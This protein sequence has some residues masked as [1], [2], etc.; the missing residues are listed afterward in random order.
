MRDRLVFLLAGAAGSQVTVTL[1]NGTQ[2]VGI[3]GSAV[4]ESE[5]GVTLHCARKT[6]PAPKAGEEP[7]IKAT[8]ILQPRDVKSMETAPIDLYSSTSAPAAPVQSA[9]LSLNNDSFRTDVQITGTSQAD[10]QLRTLQQWSADDGASESNAGLTSSTS[11]NKAWNQFAANEKL[12]GLRS[13]YSEELYTTKLD[14]SGKD[15]SER[16]RKAEALA[17]EIMA[18]RWLCYTFSPFIRSLLTL[19]TIALWLLSRP[20][21][22]TPMLLK[23]AVR[24]MN[25][26]KL[27]FPKRTS[28]S[29]LLFLRLANF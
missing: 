2:F 14:R 13:D 17:N 7:E 12:F 5:M 15:F 11:G 29:G 19:I 24:K 8:L 1:K 16:E 27:V 4:V 18:V 22:A 9:N 26:V 3:F 6:A 23:S 20:V 28:A 21:P 25:P 10:G